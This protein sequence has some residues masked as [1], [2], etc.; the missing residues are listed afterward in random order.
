M[1]VVALNTCIAYGYK[2]GDVLEIFKNSPYHKELKYAQNLTNPK[3]FGR[4]YALLCEDDYEVFNE[5]KIIGYEVTKKKV[6]SVLG[7][8][9]FVKT[10]KKP[11]KAGD[12]K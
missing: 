2:K 7:I 3:N 6:Y 9:L 11:I 8:P 5:S 12:G 10:T 4:D 1:K